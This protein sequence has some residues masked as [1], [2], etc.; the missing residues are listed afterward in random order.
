MIAK[1]CTYCGKR[2][3]LEEFTYKKLQQ[4]HYSTCDECRE[5]TK[6]MRNSKKIGSSRLYKRK[7]TP[8]D[9][10]DYNLVMGAFK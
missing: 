6:A 5:H 2:K 1:R 3:S 8:I 7:D 9:M 4:Q 10:T